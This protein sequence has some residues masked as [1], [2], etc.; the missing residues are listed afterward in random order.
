MTFGGAIRV[1]WWYSLARDIDENPINQ[2]QKEK[3]E[4]I[5]EN[6]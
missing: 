1:R 6:R 3:E 4:K 2:R 5:K